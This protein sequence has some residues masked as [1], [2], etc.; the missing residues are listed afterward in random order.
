MV[1]IVQISFSLCTTLI[2]ND[3]EFKDAYMSINHSNCVKKKYMIP[4]YLNI[5]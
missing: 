2:N 4:W 1:I 3:F 5:N